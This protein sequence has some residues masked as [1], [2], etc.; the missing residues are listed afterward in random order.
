M[1]KARKNRFFDPH[2]TA[3]AEALA[4]IPLASFGQ[5]FAAYAIDFFFVLVTYIPVEIARQY[6]LLSVRHQKL[7]IHIEFDYHQPGNIIWLVLYFGLIV[8][9][10]NGL[11]PG[12]RLLRI[13][14]VSLVHPKITLW[15]AVER[16]LGYGAS[17]LE[18]GSGFFQYFTH[19]NHCCVHDRIAETIVV[20]D[21]REAAPAK[22]D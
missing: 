5:R 20:K 13:R 4:G 2:D 18:L 3:R 19:H 21:R 9:K 15:Q 7:D 17:V 22:H 10:T 11:T 1:F 12:K 6:V 8:W 16:A 14:I